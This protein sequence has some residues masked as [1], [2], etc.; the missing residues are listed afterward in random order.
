MNAKTRK[1]TTLVALL[2]FCSFSLV[3][4]A[5]AQSKCK[6]AKGN[7]FD[8]FD[9]GATIGTITNSGFLDGTTFTVYTGSFVFTPD[10]NVVSYISETTITNDKGQLRT[11]NVYAYNI[12]TGLWT[13]MGTI[14]PNTSNGRYAGATGVVYFNGTTVGAFPQQSYPS[15]IAGEICFAP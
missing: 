6:Q 7:W 3:Q 11:N 8:S 10:P 2:T 12:V 9:S 13:A 4:S 5:S 1:L 15:E 14:N